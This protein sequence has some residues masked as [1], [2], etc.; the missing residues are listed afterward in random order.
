MNLSEK[1][2]LAVI[3]GGEAAEKA[4]PIIRKNSYFDL[5]AV[6]CKSKELIG[7]IPP[8]CRKER[9]DELFNLPA[10][11]AIYIATPPDTHISIARRFLEYGKHVLI[12]KPLANE[13]SQVN[14]LI[15]PTGLTIGV[16]LKKRFGDW[17]PHF[18]SLF[19][20]ELGGLHI[21][22]TWKINKPSTPWR[23]QL[24]K[25]GGGVLMDLGPHILD[26]AEF[27]CGSI[28]KISG[29][30]VFGDSTCCIDDSVWLHMVHYHGTVTDLSLSWRGKKR[31]Y[32]LNAVR[33]TKHLCHK[34][35]VGQ[36]D[37]LELQYNNCYQVRLLSDSRH[38]Y[39][40]LFNNFAGAIYGRRNGLPTLADGIRNLRLIS[41]AY[42]AIHSG[43][44]VNIADYSE[45]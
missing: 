2:V 19:H 24:E 23:F 26:L 14:A 7:L 35:E 44:T 36:E 13:S 21:E 25:A 37:T 27:L 30:A 12:E 4:I 40:G 33:G 17:I 42:Q 3:G 10:I 6:Q 20:D 1:L 39:E 43:G 15:V 18:N 8:I 45:K 16:A 28:L 32:C 22:L 9:L 41:A 5:Q 38:E 29:K 11:S 34:R 31:E